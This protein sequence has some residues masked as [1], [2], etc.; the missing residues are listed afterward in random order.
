VFVGD[1]ATDEHGFE[2]VE[3]RGGIAIRIG[4]GP[5]LASHR[6]TSPR[7]LHRLLASWEF[8]TEPGSAAR[9]HQSMSQD[10]P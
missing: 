3:G 10:N 8:A 6:L 7:E 5:T 2:V 1:D 9:T 4:Q